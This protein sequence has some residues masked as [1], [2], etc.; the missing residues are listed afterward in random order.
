M[1]AMSIEPVAVV[2]D[3]GSPLRRRKMSEIICRHAKSD[4]EAIQVA[5]A[6][7]KA[8]C[9]VFSVTYESEPSFRRW[10]VWGK[11]NPT[12]T[13]IRYIDEQID[14]DVYPEY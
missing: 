11:F 9:Y 2:E 5:Q 13:E 1:K 14:Q 7:E 3:Q 6:M 12:E 10:S 4:Y 8:S